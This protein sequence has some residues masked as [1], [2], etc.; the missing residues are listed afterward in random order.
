VKKLVVY[1][2][3]SSRESPSVPVVL[4]F[5]LVTSSPP[6]FMARTSSTYTGSLPQHRVLTPFVLAGSS[7]SSTPQPTSNTEF[8]PSTNISTDSTTSIPQQSPSETDSTEPSISPQSNADPSSNTSS[9]Q[10]PLNEPFVRYSRRVLVFLSKSPLAS[11]PPGMP[12]LKE[13][14]G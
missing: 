5:L 10:K 8:G 9:S 7:A 4:N 3:P 11:P 12:P 1:W 13:W 14:F 2:D 6:V